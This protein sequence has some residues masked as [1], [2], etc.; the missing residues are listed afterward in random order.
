MLYLW[1]VVVALLVIIKL[2]PGLVVKIFITL[3]VTLMACSWLR[4]TYMPIIF[5]LHY[6]YTMLQVT[7]MIKY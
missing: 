4:V 6:V 3:I 5:I 7:F 1:Q 2:M